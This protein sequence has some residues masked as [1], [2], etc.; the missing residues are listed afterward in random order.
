MLIL[1]SCS[2]SSRSP[3]SAAAGSAAGAGS[4]AG[5]ASASAPPSASRISSED[6][7]CARRIGAEYDG[8]YVGS[9]MPDFKL[10]PAYSPTADQPRAIESI[11]E[12][13]EAGEEFVTLLGA[14]GTG[15]T[16][17]MAAT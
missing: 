16:F 7:S 9:A 10:N 13:L 5:P 17:T 2:G 4:P 6:Q 3:A 8:R 15:K 14:T 1:V 12:G 11:A